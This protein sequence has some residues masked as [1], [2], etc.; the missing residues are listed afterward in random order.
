MKKLTILC[1][2][3]A[4]QRLNRTLFNLGTVE[5]VDAL[6]MHRDAEG[7]LKHREVSTEECD[8]QLTRINFVLSLID[9]FAPEQKG[10]VEGLAPVP[11]IIEQR[12]VDE[13]I[14]KVD[15]AEL[16]KEAQ[17]LDDARKHAER[18]I[19]EVSAQLEALAPLANLPFALGDLRKPT[20]VRLVLGSIPAKNLD[21]L[22]NRRE[23]AELIAWERV[24]DAATLRSG[25]GDSESGTGKTDRVRIVAAFLPDNEDAARR[26][27]A[28]EQFEETALP[29]FPG[30]IRDRIRELTGDR[31]ESVEQLNQVRD[32]VTEMS[33]LRRTL[34]VLKAH[35][36]GV[37]RRL[38]AGGSA[39]EGRWVHVLT[40][41]IRERDIPQL[42]AAL[43]KEIPEAGV[44]YEDPRPGDNV[45]VSLSLPPMVR[46]VKMLVNLFG[47]P[48]YTAFDPSPFILV[49]FFLFFGICFGDVGYGLMLTALGTYLSAKTRDFEGLNNFSRIFVFA[50]ISTT[51]F[52]VV[53]G[54]WFGDL[55]KYFGEG[56]VLQQI[57]DRFTVLDPLADPVTMLVAALAL[58]ML[59]QFYGIALK[60]YGALKAGDKVGAFC[61]G[62]LW[63]ITLP[64]MV[65][66]VATIFVPVPD[67]VLRIGLAIFV[68]GA[69]GLIL[70]QGR[71][72]KGVVGK[73]G[74]GVVSL[75]GIV[76]SY[77]CTAFIGDTL[78]YCRLLALALTTSI[79]ALTV[80]MIAG[81][82]RD[83][84]VVGPV[85]FVVVLVAGHLFNFSISLL[86]AFVH[87]MRLIFVEF[88]GRFY[89]GGAKPFT[90]FGF[91]SPSYM[92]RRTADVK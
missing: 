20:R 70:S 45:P 89:E 40:G 91:D 61:D 19:S 72:A 73:L 28:A 87:A 82:L 39:I 66:I 67:V 38:L 11:L 57:K 77:G 31:A 9:E 76:G 86:G 37:R 4:A 78:S 79:V 68:L 58:G 56:N 63:L 36:E 17:A 27:L 80:N 75:Y 34:H 26:A 74:T 21:S 6:A 54:S 84:S 30:T 92:L 71:D 69:L 12:E 8:L 29:T 41:Y 5:V 24:A 33:K 48:A 85:L 51:F 3:N 55:P 35:W 60:A 15:L 22:K 1:P 47:L 46:P 65:I 88:F 64:G 13:A 42:E 32:R 2:V 7:A 81:L 49:N 14:R 62:I 18:R 25:D 50:G 23:T 90:P 16:Y 52:G 59:N 83:I 10:F 53:M 43:R 44:A